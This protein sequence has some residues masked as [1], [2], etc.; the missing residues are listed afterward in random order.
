MGQY[1]KMVGNDF[2]A[3]MMN[4]LLV[5]LAAE[6][7]DLEVKKKQEISV[8]SCVAKNNF[9]MLS[10]THSK[11][12]M[13]QNRCYNKEWQIWGGYAVSLCQGSFLWSTSAQRESPSPHCAPPHSCLH[14]LQLQTIEAIGSYSPHGGNETISRIRLASRHR[15]LLFLEISLPRHRLPRNCF[16]RSRQA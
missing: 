7:K 4:P 9:N 10:W 5:A 14:P 11:L 8:R 13:L 12:K 3:S 6:D 15:R 1:V 16:T 2:L